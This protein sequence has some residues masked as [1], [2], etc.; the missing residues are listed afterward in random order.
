[1]SHGAG[2]QSLLTWGAQTHK[3]SLAPGNPFKEK[4]KKRVKPPFLASLRAMSSVMVVT[5]LFPFPAGVG[6]ALAWGGAELRTLVFPTCPGELW[7][8]SR[9]SLSL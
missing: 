4:K 8:R 6:S 9:V 7:G 1:M 3:K 5:S 2:A